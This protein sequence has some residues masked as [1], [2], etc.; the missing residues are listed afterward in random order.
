M[1]HWIVPGSRNNWEWNMRNHNRWGCKKPIIKQMVS[2]D[3]FIIYCTKVCEIIGIG[4]VVE[5]KGYISERP[6]KY[7]YEFG[8]QVEKL[9]SP[10]SFREFCDKLEFTSGLH[11]REWGQKLRNPRKI[12]EEDFRIL[13]AALEK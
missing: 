13:A 2:G 1:N 8:Y 5:N 6:D 4:V 11:P 10:V 12:T 9:S 7:Q 3:K